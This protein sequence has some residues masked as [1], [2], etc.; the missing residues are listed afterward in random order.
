MMPQHAHAA[1]NAAPEAVMTPRVPD[2]Q[3][4]DALVAVA[5]SEDQAIA[6]H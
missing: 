2:T 1:S 5:T 4:L 6:Q 3:R